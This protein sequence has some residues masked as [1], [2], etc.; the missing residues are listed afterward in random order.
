MSKFF[1]DYGAAVGPAL[2]FLFGIAALFV[3]Q[4][5]DDAAARRK[6]ET[7]VAKI[8]EMVRLSPPP[9]YEVPDESDDATSATLSNMANF[10][11]FYDRMATI[12]AAITIG[13]AA[14]HEHAKAITIIRFQRI[15]WCFDI[16]MSEHCFF[17]QEGSAHGIPDFDNA[18]NIENAWRALLVAAELT[19]LAHPDY[20][21]TI[22]DP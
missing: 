3:K 10:A 4:K 17:R 15:K 16:I 21:I 18:A 13:E 1:R 11:H 20:M 14:I 9:R 7:R 8:V 12:Q 19:S 5:F 22:E 6:A 2:A